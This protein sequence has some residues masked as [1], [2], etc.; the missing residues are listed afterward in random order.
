MLMSVLFC[1]NVS[2]L[3]FGIYS[4]AT[5]ISPIV[6]PIDHS[7]S[8]SFIFLARKNNNKRNVPNN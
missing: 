6:V 4:G 3:I 5:P 1:Q 8:L 2:V 7:P